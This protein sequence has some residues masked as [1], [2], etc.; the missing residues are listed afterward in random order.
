MVRNEIDGSQNNLF[1]KKNFTIIHN[2][3]QIGFMI[4]LKKL[5]VHSVKPRK[6]QISEGG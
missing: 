4:E 5:S 1:N 6:I 2:V 3:L